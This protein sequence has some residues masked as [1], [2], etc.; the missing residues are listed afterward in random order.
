MPVIF[1]KCP[2][3]GCELQV[4]AVLGLEKQLSQCPSCHH[5]APVGDFLPK[6]SLRLGDKRFQLRFGRQWVG[7]MAAGS[8]VEV[9]I[10]DDSRYMSRRHAVVELC[11]TALGVRCTFEEHGKNPTSIK[12]VELVEDDVVYLAPNDCLKM[13]D[14]EMYLANEYE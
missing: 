11:C 2:R 5:R 9:Q 7:R 12:G 3:C 8:D 4:N 6:Y 13:G 1:I 10:K 14:K